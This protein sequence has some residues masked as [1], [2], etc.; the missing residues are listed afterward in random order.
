MQ[1]VHEIIYSFFMASLSA[2]LANMFAAITAVI[3]LATAT[4]P[5]ANAS[6]VPK[7]A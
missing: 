6:E 2:C 4:G 7:M 3:K 5:T 1:P